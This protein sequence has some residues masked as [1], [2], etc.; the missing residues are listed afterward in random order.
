M[1]THADDQIRQHRRKKKCYGYAALDHTRHPRRAAGGNGDTSSR[2]GSFPG[3][4]ASSSEV[5]P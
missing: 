1:L 4:T 2:G 3:T 5:N